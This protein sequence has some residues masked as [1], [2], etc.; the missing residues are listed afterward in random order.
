MFTAIPGQLRSLRPVHLMRMRQ[1]ESNELKRDLAEETHALL[2]M[3]S[4]CMAVFME[5]GD[6]R[7][8]KRSLRRTQLTLTIRPPQ[9]QLQR[10]VFIYCNGSALISAADGI[11]VDGDA[12]SRRRRESAIAA[13]ATHQSPLSSAHHGADEK[14]VKGPL[15][16]IDQ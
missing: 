14:I 16:L 13:Y 8:K 6:A 2:F 1:A 15:L 4:T 5:H 7:A 3:A 12:P 9:H 11:E 10:T